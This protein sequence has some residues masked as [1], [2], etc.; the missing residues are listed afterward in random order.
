M[1][2]ESRN[3]D[4][5]CEFVNPSTCCL[6]GIE[7]QFPPRRCERLHGVANGHLCHFGGNGREKMIQ[8][9]KIID[10]RRTIFTTLEEISAYCRVRQWVVCC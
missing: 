7:N 8:E 9:A 10:L 3:C 4:A 2:N 1:S 5:D 6:F